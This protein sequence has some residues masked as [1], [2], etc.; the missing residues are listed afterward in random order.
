[1][2]SQC[3]AKSYIEFANLRWPSGLPECQYCKQCDAV[4]TKCHSRRN[5]FCF[6]CEREFSVTSGTIF[7]GSKLSFTQIMKLITNDYRFAVDLARDLTIGYKPAWVWHQKIKEAKGSASLLKRPPSPRYKGYFQR[8]N[9]D[10]LT[11][12]TN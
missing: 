3:E 12:P 10:L 9:I 1:M 4:S 2:T 6:R 8:G 7:H 11:P 5:Y